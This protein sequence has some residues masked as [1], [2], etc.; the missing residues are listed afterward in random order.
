VVSKP[1]DALAQTAAVEAIRLDEQE[2]P[3]REAAR[4]KKQVDEARLQQDKA[5]LANK[6]GFRP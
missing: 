2:A 4:Q 1:L 3:Q 5:R 6:S